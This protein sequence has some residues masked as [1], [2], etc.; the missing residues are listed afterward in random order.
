MG[1]QDCTS[2]VGS[3]LPTQVVG[4]QVGLGQV[5]YVLT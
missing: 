1:F 4:L 3:Y 5:S 2:L